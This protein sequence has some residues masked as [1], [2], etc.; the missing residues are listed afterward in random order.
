MQSGTAE[1]PFCICSR[2]SPIKNVED[3]PSSEAGTCLMASHPKQNGR[4]T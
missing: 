2:H 4:A 1:R 3:R